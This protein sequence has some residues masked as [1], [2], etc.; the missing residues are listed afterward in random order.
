M[1]SD[2]QKLRSEISSSDKWN[3]EAMYASETGFSDDIANPGA[4]VQILISCVIVVG[5]TLLGIAGI[6]KRDIA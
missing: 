5:L 3:I 2:K 6:D 4:P 1:N